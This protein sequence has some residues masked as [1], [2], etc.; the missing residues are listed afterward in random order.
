MFENHCNS[1]I[2]KIKKIVRRS[3]VTTYKHHGIPLI[4]ILGVMQPN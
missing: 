3:E 2:K 1:Y 4:V